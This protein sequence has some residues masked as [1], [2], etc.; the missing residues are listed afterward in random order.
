MESSCQKFDFLFVGIL[1][2][3]VKTRFQGKGSSKRSIKKFLQKMITNGLLLNFVKKKK[4]E[5]KTVF[6]KKS[7]P[8]SG[9]MGTNFAR[10][11]TMKKGSLGVCSRSEEL[12]TKKLWS[13][14]FRLSEKKFPSHSSSV[15]F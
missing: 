1:T 5:K 2:S 9:V 13:S 10:I 6:C 3:K 8:H 4:K 14:N 12:I 11:M 7:R 15:N